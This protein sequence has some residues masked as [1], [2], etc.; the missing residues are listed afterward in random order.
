MKLFASTRKVDDTLRHN[1]LPVLAELEEIPHQNKGEND[2]EELK[3][4]STKH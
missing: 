1:L 3:I 2:T 4:A